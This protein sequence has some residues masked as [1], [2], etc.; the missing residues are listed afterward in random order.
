MT[1][2]RLSL[3]AILPFVL[4]ACGS[5]DEETPNPG[6]G[7]SQDA[8]SDSPTT[9]PKDGGTDTGVTPPDNDGG[10]GG[11]SDVGPDTTPPEEKAGFD[12]AKLRE[13]VANGE[14]VSANVMPSVKGVIN[15]FVEEDPTIEP[16]KTAKDNTT[17]I[18]NQIT[19]ATQGTCNVVT[20]RGTDD[21]F[22]SATFPSGCTLTNGMTI[23]G[24]VKVEVSKVDGADGGLP[25]V[26][27][28]FTFTDLTVNTV[29]LNGSATISTQDAKTYP[30]TADMK[31]S[32]YG[33]LTFAGE[34]SVAASPDA[35][36]LNASAKLS[37]KGTYEK[38]A[39]PTGDAGVS[40]AALPGPDLGSNGWACGQK[41][42]SNY[43]LKD[44]TRTF[45]DCYANGGTITVTKD[46]GCSKKIG[47]KTVEQ[48]VTTSTLLEWLPT[49][50]TDGKINVTVTTG[51][52]KGQTTSVPLPWKCS[53]PTP[54]DG[55]T[56]A[57]PSDAATGG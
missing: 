39:A 26:T 13:G 9:P 40:D 25:T 5:S 7:G 56:D 53:T 11:G 31:A 30:M 34:G 18:I 51:A 27:V 3:L 46:Y 2:R 17:N 41:G 22:F 49:T 16:A 32:T 48:T 47:P 14:A 23:S 35:G 38:A 45:K 29:V 15:L 36:A 24:Q 28:K 6:G 50:P 4:S 43:V 1:L 21:P 44:L 37:G 54:A 55:G 19:K 10:G 12:E 57:A 42:T 8:A 20:A 52:T 33:S